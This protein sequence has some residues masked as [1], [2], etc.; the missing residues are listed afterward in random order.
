MAP[1]VISGSFTS[2]NGNADGYGMAALDPTTGGRRTGSLPR[3]RRRGHPQRGTQAAI[4]Q[5]STDANTVCGWVATSAPAAP[6]RGP[7]ALEPADGAI[8]WLQDCHGDGYDVAAAGDTV[9]AVGHAHFCGNTFGVP[10]T[11]PGP[12][13][14]CL[15]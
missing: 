14:A 8:Q 7:F 4:Y 13:N 10:Q 2:V 9:Y 3:C 6:W 11:N 1:V 5:L 15:S 12:S